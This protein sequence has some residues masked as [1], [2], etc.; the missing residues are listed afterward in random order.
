[1]LRD[2]FSGIGCSIFRAV[3]LEYCQSKEAICSTISNFLLIFSNQL[4]FVLPVLLLS[5]GARGAL[6]AECHSFSGGFV[7]VILWGGQRRILGGGAEFKNKACPCKR[8]PSEWVNNSGGYSLVWKSTG[9]RSALFVLL[10]L[11]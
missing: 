7:R 5:D 6:L 1:M 11:L 3:R 8:F 9:V 2:F 4:R 10:S